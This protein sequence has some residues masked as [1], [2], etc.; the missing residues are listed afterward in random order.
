MAN[1]SNSGL[2]S[3]IGRGFFGL[4]SIALTAT[5]SVIVQ[6][7]FDTMT[8]TPPTPQEAPSQPI[9]PN[10]AAQPNRSP[11]EAP[12]TITFDPPAE[13]LPSDA[14]PLEPLPSERSTAIELDTDAPEPPSPEADPNAEAEDSQSR[15]MQKFWEKLLNH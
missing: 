4:L 13:V 3:L 7:S 6:R 9:A 5:V 11:E 12:P 1:S 14:L 10:S 2:S 15:V 8:R